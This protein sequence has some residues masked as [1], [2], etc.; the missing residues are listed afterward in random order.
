M[1][2]LCAAVYAVIAAGRAIF[3]DPKVAL[4]NTVGQLRYHYLGAIPIVVLTCLALREVGRIGPLRALPRPLL[5]AVVL[6]IG[7]Y[8]YAPSPFRI[9]DTMFCR[10]YLDTAMRGIEGEALAPPAGST[11]YL[12]N[13]TPPVGLGPVMLK[14]DFP[15]R[16]AVLLLHQ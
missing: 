14:R 6:V 9:Y 10:I 3:F 11:V 16:A 7:G 13:G 1:A 12:D 5:L 2:V 15:G 8:G 4:S